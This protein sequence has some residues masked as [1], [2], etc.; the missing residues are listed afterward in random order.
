MVSMVRL[1]FMSLTYLAQV[2]PLPSFDNLT[3][4]NHMVDKME[5]LGLWLMYEMPG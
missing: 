5:E 3:A 1:L 4:F 2:H